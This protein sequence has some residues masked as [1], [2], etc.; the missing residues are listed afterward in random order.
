MTSILII[1]CSSTLASALGPV[2]KGT[3]QV[4]Y[5]GRSNGK[6]HTDLLT[7]SALPLQRFDVVVHLAADFGGHTIADMKRAEQ[8]NA[9]G[10]LRVCELASAVQAKHLIVIS[11]SSAGL[12]NSDPGI[13]IYAISKRHGDELAQFYCSNKNIP[14][15]ILRPSQ[16]YDAK[17][18]CR[19][20]QPMFYSMIDKAER[21]ED[22]PLF[23]SHDAVRNFVYLDDFCEIICRVIE[24]RIHGQFYVTSS[25][26]TLTQIANT[27]YLEFGKG[28]KVVF[29][30]HKADIPD[31][32][33]FDSE[34]LY[35]KIG[36]RPQTS[37][38]VGI[39]MIKN[40]RQ[41]E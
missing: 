27:A 6:I 21:G 19:K 40:W 32:P 28:G 34:D 5:A 38:S 14:L 15:T 22:I 26:C 39:A 3:C 30:Q 10:M 11:S 9:V 13:T 36:Y 4:T 41:F 16:L 29:Q 12:K 7:D 8:A 2:L 1:G 18:N 23:G 20:H 31:L 37:L 17:S 24:R 33:Y 25:P 35:D